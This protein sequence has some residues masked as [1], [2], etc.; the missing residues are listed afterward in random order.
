MYVKKK[1][2]DEQLMYTKC[3][4]VLVFLVFWFTD[5]HLLCMNIGVARM[6]LYVDNIIAEI[7]E[8][9]QHWT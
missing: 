1:V 8:K 5:I 6:C 3:V 7:S 9:F 4:S 2:G